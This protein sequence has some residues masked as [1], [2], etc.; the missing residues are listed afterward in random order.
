MASGRTSWTRSKARLAVG[1][2][3]ALGAA[4]Q[5]DHGAAARRQQLRQQS[6]DRLADRLRAQAV[7][8]ALPGRGAAM[9]LSTTAAG[10]PAAA[11]N[12]AGVAGSKTSPCSISAPATGATSRQIQADHAAAAGRGHLRPAAGRAAQIQHRAP[13]LE[14]T[15]AAIDLQELVGRA[16]P[17]AFLPRAPHV[18]IVE[19]AAQ[20][21]GRSGTAALAANP[22]PGAARRR[23]GLRRRAAGRQ[24]MG[25]PDGRGRL[26]AV[27][28]R[29]LERMTHQAVQD[30]LA[31]TR[32]PRP[33]ARS[34]ARC[35][36]SIRGSRSRPPPDPRGPARCRDARPGRRCSCRASAPTRRRSRRDRAPARRSCG[37]RSAA[38]SGRPPQAW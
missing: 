1:G 24:L 16:R 9:S 37:D 5:L 33:A 2:H 19:M 32:D 17:I 6:E 11:R 15:E 20:P 25:L 36:G 34:P 22:D 7:D 13:R 14:Q 29:R 31:Q 28:Q 18:R 35:A 12:L 27:V 21:P 10:P 4:H 38:G 23:H 30:A 3:A 26:R 8:R